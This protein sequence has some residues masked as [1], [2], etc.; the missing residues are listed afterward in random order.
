MNSNILATMTAKTNIT[1]NNDNCDNSGSIATLRSDITQM[2]P[3]V[4]NEDYQYCWWLLGTTGCHLCSHAEQLLE[5]FRAVY[6]IYYRYVDIADFDEALMMDFA[7]RI[8]VLL[9]PNQRLDYPFSVM[10]LQ[11]L[12]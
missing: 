8:P 1:I 4:N 12:L 2:M 6:P 7:T 10:D 9:T 11:R 5:R 3:H